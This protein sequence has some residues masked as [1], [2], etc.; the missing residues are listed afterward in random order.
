MQS[1]QMGYTGISPRFPVGIGVVSDAKDLTGL[2]LQLVML[3][4]ENIDMDNVQQMPSDY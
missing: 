4:Y 1:S 2:I 3:R